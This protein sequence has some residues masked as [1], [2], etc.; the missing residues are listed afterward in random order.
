L[1]NSVHL[2]LETMV[3][4]IKVLIKSK[5]SKGVPRITRKSTKGKTGSG[6]GDERE[7]YNEHLERLIERCRPV[8]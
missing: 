6:M 1:T 4:E 7:G 3:L 2:F 5:D 8:K